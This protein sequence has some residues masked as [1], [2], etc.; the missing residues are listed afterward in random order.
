MHGEKEVTKILRSVM[1]FI[2][3]TVLTGIVLMAAFIIFY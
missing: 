3:G 1:L 2:C